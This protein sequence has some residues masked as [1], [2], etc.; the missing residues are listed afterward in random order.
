MRV[1]LFDVFGT[2]V[3]WRSSLI[4][5][6]ETASVRADWPAVIDDWRRAYQP[7]LDR[8]RR[9]PEWRDLDAVQRET[10]DDVLAAHGISLPDADRDTLIRG[11]MN[12]L[13]E[14]G[15]PRGTHVVSLAFGPGL[16]IAAALMVKT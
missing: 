5:I 2:L 16:T 14:Q 4:D 10:L 7:A 6:A 13:G 3:D 11:W 12:L 8:V 9:Q 1:L 15:V